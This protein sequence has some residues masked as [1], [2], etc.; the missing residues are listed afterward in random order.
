MAIPNLS[1]VEQYFERA[2][3]L[4]PK[5]TKALYELAK[6]AFDKKQFKKVLV[7]V[8]QY[9]SV[10]QL[11]ASILILGYQAAMKL[12]AKDKAENFAWFLKN[13]FSESFEY[14]QWLASSG[15]DNRQSN[16]S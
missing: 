7:R 9:H 16:I 11:S 10:N 2:Y 4:G 13:R 12:G 14:K 3:I 15:Y 1:Q 6:I 5:R 8:E